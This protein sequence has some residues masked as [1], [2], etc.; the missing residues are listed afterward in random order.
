MIGCQLSILHLRDL[1]HHVKLLA[2]WSQGV[3]VYAVKYRDLIFGEK[4]CVCAD[5]VN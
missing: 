1:W 4:R 5:N 2:E 3:I